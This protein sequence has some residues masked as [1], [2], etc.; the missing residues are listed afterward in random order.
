[1]RQGS[2]SGGRPYTLTGKRDVSLT[3]LARERHIEGKGFR[4]T[5]PRK[6]PRS[7]LS[8]AYC[9]SSKHQARISTYLCTYAYI[10]S[11]NK[12]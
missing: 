4:A 12:N 8:R 7:R 2:D 1:M 6:C 10:V 9:P 5:T 3:Y 11:S